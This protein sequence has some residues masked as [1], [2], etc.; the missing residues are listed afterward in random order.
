MISR[1]QPCFTRFSCTLNG[2]RGSSLR[3]LRDSFLFSF[4]LAD[5]D[6]M[7]RYMG[8]NSWFALDWTNFILCVCFSV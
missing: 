1:A 4:F 7:C 2:L 8:A 5:V 3:A 6:H